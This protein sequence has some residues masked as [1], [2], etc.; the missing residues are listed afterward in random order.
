AP[1]SFT[2]HAGII[3][4]PGGGFNGPTAPD[5]SQYGFLQSAFSGQTPGVFSQTI[6]FTLA[7]TYQLAY[8]VAG[9]PPNGLGSFGDLPYDVRLDSTVIGTDSSTSSEP[10]T[11]VI[12][13]FTTTAGDHTLTFETSQSNGADNTAFIDSVSIQAVPEPTSLALFAIGGVAFAA[14]RRFRRVR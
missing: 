3:N 9:R 6:S 13:T 11:Q 10:F 7:G 8:L 5:G 1:W 4:A 2:G 12:F 14:A